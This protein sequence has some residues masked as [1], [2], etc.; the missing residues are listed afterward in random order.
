LMTPFSPTLI[1]GL[2]SNSLPTVE[3]TVC[4]PCCRVVVAQAIFACKAALSGSTDRAKARFD[5]V[6]SCLQRKEG[7][8]GGMEKKRREY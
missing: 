7:G 6:Y 5:C 2:V 8:R 4:P 1:K 3:G